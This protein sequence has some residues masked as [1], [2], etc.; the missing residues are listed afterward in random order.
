MQRTVYSTKF[1][2]VVNEI[3]EKGG[4]TSRL[5]TITIH[6]SDE[7]KALK[8]AVKI[9]GMFAPIKTEKVSGLYK[10]D[11]EEFFKHATLVSE[12]VTQ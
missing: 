8:K 7:K 11:D 4:I 2:Y 10:L 5:E 1:T 6:E 9:V 3:D 12:E